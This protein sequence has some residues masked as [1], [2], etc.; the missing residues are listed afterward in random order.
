MVKRF[1]FYGVDVLGND[2]SISM[3]IEHTS[4]VFPDVADAIFSVWD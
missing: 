1:F 3:S 4:S 2:F